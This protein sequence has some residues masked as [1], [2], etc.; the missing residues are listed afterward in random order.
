LVQALSPE[1]LSLVARHEAA[2]LDLGHQRWLTVAAALD[3][4]IGLLRPLRN[5]TA[6]WRRSLERCADEIAAGS[7][8]DRRR[9][10]R[11]ALVDLSVG[12]A[13]PAVAA[14]GAADTVLERTD[15]LLEPPPTASWAVRLLVYGP[16]IWGIVVA[17]VLLLAWLINTGALLAFAGR[18]P[19]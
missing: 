16:A 5:S 19:H 17:A 18:C 14:F 6:A 11:S 13:G 7:D 12:T 9:L 2:H 4:S 10:L 8:L 1:Q 15:A 3:R